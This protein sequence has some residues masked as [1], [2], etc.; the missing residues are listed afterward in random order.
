MTPPR[1]PY[2]LPPHPEGP[3]FRP[4]PA[5]K[6]RS[7]IDIVITSVTLLFAALAALASFGYSLLWGMT[8]DTCDTSGAACN[9]AALGQA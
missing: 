8:T 3:A 9:E 2:F 1:Y 7:L 4:V 6:R 5:P